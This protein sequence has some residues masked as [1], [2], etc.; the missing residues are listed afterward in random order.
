MQRHAP[1]QCA[2]LALGDMNSQPQ[3]MPVDDTV[4]IDDHAVP[5]PDAQNAQNPTALVETQVPLWTAFDYDFESFFDFDFEPTGGFPVPDTDMV[6]GIGTPAMPHVISN[7]DDRSSVVTNI[8]LDATPRDQA[9]SIPGNVTTSPPISQRS[10]GV[11]NL[12]QLDPVQAKCQEI[13]DVLKQSTTI[14]MDD[15]ALAYI[16]RDTLVCSV[17]LYGKRFQHILPIL[18]TPS[19]AL[20]TASPILLL[21]IVLVGSCC[22]PDEIIPRAA[23]DELGRALFVA[24]GN[25][26]VSS[27]ICC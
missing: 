8:T 14:S 7:S 19:F 12:T 22:S 6:P 1:R 23:V 17:S 9:N 18:H 2:E 11:F 24:I 20:T 27:F 25:Q 13:I 16:T 5:S 4:I 3:Q 15:P 21:A 10:A 26:A